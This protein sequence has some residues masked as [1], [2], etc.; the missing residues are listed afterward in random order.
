MWIIGFFFLDYFAEFLT[1]MFGRQIKTAA[2]GHLPVECRT[3]ALASSGLDTNPST[4]LS[5]KRIDDANS[6]TGFASGSQW[7]L[8][9]SRRLH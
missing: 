9:F 8:D 6:M 3:R 4:P 1:M 2:V 5:G 7:G